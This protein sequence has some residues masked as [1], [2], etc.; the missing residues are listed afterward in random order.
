LDGSAFDTKANGIKNKKNKEKIMNK[1]MR[2][3]EISEST[4]CTITIRNKIIHALA[5]E[6][7]AEFDKDLSTEHKTII[8][9]LAVERL[10]QQLKETADHT[11]EQMQQELEALY[12]KYDQI[13]NKALEDVEQD[14]MQYLDGL[15]EAFLGKKP[16]SIEKE[17]TEVGDEK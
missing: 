16:A 9:K 17:N 11:M 8:A 12:S 4:R 6:C 15:I 1:K 5:F 3:A 14:T 7:N 13:S 2:N 10:D